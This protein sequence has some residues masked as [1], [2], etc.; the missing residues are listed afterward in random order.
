MSD[1]SGLGFE[2]AAY[3]GFARWLLDQRIVAPNGLHGSS[4]FRRIYTETDSCTPIAGDIAAAAH[5]IGLLAER[6]P[7]SDFGPSS[8]A[9]RIID[10]DAATRR[11]F[12][13]LE[14]VCSGIW[15]L[16]CGGAS[17]HATN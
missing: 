11:A 8:T 6:G 16:A 5:Q 4:N 10:L 1:R 13:N 2:V 12:Q 9:D 14:A 3:I 15:Y 17:P 7:A